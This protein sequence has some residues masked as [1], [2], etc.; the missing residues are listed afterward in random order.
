MEAAAPPFPSA[1]QA[2][3]V[4]RAHARGLVW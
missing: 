4:P 3:T 1:A 2:D